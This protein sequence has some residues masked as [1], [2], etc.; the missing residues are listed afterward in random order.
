MSNVL[1]K[2]TRKVNQN[3]KREVEYVGTTTDN[4]WELEDETGS[5]KLLNMR[6]RD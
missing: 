4:G 5:K 2:S 3:I 1:S 6:E